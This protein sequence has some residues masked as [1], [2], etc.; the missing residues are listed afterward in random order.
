LVTQLVDAIELY[1]FKNLSSFVNM[2]PF[3]S[4]SLTFPLPRIPVTETY[5]NSL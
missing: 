4:K 5:E 1:K 3:E 2:I